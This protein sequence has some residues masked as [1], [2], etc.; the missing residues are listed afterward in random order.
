MTSN[1]ARQG[2]RWLKRMQSTDYLSRSNLRAGFSQQALTL[3]LNIS[4]KSLEDLVR[5]P[6]QS[7]HLFRPNV[8]TDSGR[9]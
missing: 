9:M 2:I 5:I 7:E 1:I 6:A 8:N 4:A 3:S